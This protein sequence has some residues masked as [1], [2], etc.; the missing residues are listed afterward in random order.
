[1]KLTFALLLSATLL[2]AAEHA[3]QGF[4][5]TLTYNAAHFSAHCSTQ[6]L[7]LTMQEIGTDIP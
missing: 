5:I 4:G 1:M 3:A 6:E 2:P 7:K